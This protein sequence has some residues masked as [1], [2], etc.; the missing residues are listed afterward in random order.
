MASAELALQNSSDV[1]T[2]NLFRTTPQIDSTNIRS[3]QETFF[4]NHSFVEVLNPEKELSGNDSQTSLQEYDDL[5]NV[6]EML[7]TPC[8]D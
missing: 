6:R 4:W 5:R 2:S 3:V 1:A 8:H 7:L